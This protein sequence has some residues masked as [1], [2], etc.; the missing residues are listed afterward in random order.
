MEITK[1]LRIRESSI[2]RLILIAV[3]TMV[4]AGCDRSQTAAL[5]ESVEVASA[6]DAASD[7]SLL[8]QVE[9]YKSKADEMFQSHDHGSGGD[10]S[11]DQMANELDAIGAKL[12][13]IGTLVEKDVDASF[14]A[15]ATML[16]VSSSIPDR[17]KALDLLL[18]HHVDHPELADQMNEHPEAFGLSPGAYP[19][20]KTFEFLNAI[21]DQ[22]NL[23][24]V[25]GVAALNIGRSY[26]A[27]QEALH[28]LSSDPDI[29]FP[30]EYQTLIDSIKASKDQFALPII[31]DHYAR[32]A[33]KY[34][35][36]PLGDSTV[37]KIAAAEYKSRGPTLVARF[38]TSVGS[39]AP[40]IEG[41]DLDGTTFKLSDYRGKVVM[42]DF[43][44]HW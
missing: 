34:A 40:E 5:P 25:R 14:H 16:A 11:H 38:R 13:K 27:G 33:E 6:D 32:V 9:G 42:L 26:I 1:R 19:E 12:L 20:E 35:D 41:P 7:Q 39:V 21:A 23:E 8:D 3:G 28:V 44:G 17:R 15:L 30:P 31:K 36:V 24:A 43:W 37:G 4:A 10:H 2:G 18:Q 22:T 29:E